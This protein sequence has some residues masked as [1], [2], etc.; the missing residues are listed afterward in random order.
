MKIEVRYEV[1][2]RKSIYDG[3]DVKAPFINGYNVWDIPVK[4]YTVAVEKAIKHAYELGFKHAQSV[5][6]EMWLE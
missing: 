6:Q 1:V 4:E 3:S 5:V 2:D